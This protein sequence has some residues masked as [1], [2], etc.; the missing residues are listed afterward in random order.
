WYQM[1]HLRFSLAKISFESKQK[2]TYEIRITPLCSTLVHFEIVLF[3]YS[4]NTKA[5]ITMALL[6]L[7]HWHILPFN[8]GHNNSCHAVC[9]PWSRNKNFWCNQTIERHVS[10]FLDHWSVA[11]KARLVFWSLTILVYHWLFVVEIALL[12]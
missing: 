9:Q 2:P 6:V 1:H 10:L 12:K 5:I 4:T 8:Q 11:K 3:R 7:M